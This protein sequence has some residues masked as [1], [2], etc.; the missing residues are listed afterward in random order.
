MTLEERTIWTCFDR[1]LLM[2]EY[3][4]LLEARAE[5][6]RRRSLLTGAVVPE[7]FWALDGPRHLVKP[8][9]SPPLVS[10]VDAAGRQG[11]LEAKRLTWIEEHGGDWRSITTTSN[12]KS[13]D[14]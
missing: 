13:A 8:S 9:T 6:S 5:W 7:A 1:E 4:T 10:L 2:I 3:G 11:E 12:G 14:G